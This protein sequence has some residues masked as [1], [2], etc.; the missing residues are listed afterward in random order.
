MERVIC[1]SQL[2]K[3]SR[4][5]SVHLYGIEVLEFICLNPHNEQ[6]S[7]FLNQNYDGVPKFFNARLEVEK[8]YLFHDTPEEWEAIYNMRI[9]LIKKEIENIEHRKRT[10]TNNNGDTQ[11]K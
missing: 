7:V 9:D 10:R 6:Y 8:W 4:L 3:G 1:I 5:V 2:Q 11:F